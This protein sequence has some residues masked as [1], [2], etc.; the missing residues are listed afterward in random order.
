MRVAVLSESSAA[1]AALRMLVEGILGRQL[2]PAALPLLRSRGWPSVL[3]NLPAVLR[4]LYYRTDTEALAVVVDAD[5][6]PPH[7]PAHGQSGGAGNGCRLCQLREVVART[8]GQL[9]PVPSRH[10]PSVQTAL[11]V[12]VPAIEAWYRCGIAPHAS[13]ATLLQRLRV[14]SYTHIKNRLKRDVYGTERPS[15]VQ[16]TQVTRAAAQR[17]RQ[18]LSALEQ[19]F[20]NGFGPLANDVR[21]WLAS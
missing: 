15:T 3:H 17:L 8:Q 14:E 4:H 16:E 13:E 9:R 20:P 7:A 5:R 2:Q 21:N 10:P 12:A 11:G 19:L 6:S 1:E 18:D